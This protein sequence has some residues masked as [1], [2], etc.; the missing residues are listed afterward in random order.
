MDLFKTLLSSQ[1]GTL[2]D[3]LKNVG[4]GGEQAERFLPAFG[5][6][7]S[8]AADKTD[9]MDLGKI[10]AAIDVNALASN[11]D[12]SPSLIQQGLQAVLP[13]LREHFN[14]GSAPS[15]L[16]AAKSLF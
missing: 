2:T 5:D 6:S 7:L 9:G 13:S 15:L 1:A 10:L 12:I 3:I 11:T 8:A 4:F 16:S 14:M